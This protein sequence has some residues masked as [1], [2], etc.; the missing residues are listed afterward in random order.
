MAVQNPALIPVPM[1]AQAQVQTQT[2]M[3]ER[4][5]LLLWEQQSEQARQAKQAF[6]QVL[7]LPLLLQEGTQTE[8]RALRKQTPARQQQVPAHCWQTQMPAP[9]LRV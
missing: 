3:L 7:L 5:Q 8:T 4:R 1:V 9:P 6:V 2:Q